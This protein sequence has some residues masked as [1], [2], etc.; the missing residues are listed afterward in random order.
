MR[1]VSREL[2]SPAARRYRQNCTIASHYLLP[3]DYVVMKS[4]VA[5]MISRLRESR[6]TNWKQI[7]AINYIV[8]DN[9]SI[10]REIVGAP[11]TLHWIFYPTLIGE[12]HKLKGISQHI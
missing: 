11:L 4:I 1:V 3:R 5:R 12:P 6:A 2:V 7:K 8:G 10:S 9:I